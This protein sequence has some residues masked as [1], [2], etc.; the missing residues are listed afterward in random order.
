MNTDHVMYNAE[1]VKIVYSINKIMFEIKNSIQTT[2]PLNLG[3][4][5]SAMQLIYLRFIKLN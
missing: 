2:T 3:E 1:E 4:I 5:S